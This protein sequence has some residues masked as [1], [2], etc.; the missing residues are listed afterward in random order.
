MNKVY[1][2]LICFVYAIAFLLVAN[3]PMEYSP[4]DPDTGAMLLVGIVAG[5]VFSIWAAVTSKPW[6]RI[7]LWLLSTLGFVA[8]GISASIVCIVMMAV[9]WRFLESAPEVK[10]ALHKVIEPE[11]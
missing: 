11:N 8:F 9:M 10:D 7:A 4:N 3:D 1:F 2:F 5:V 6:V